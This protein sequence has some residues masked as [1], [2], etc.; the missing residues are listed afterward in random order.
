M[1]LQCQ[2]EFDN[3]II[4]SE[5]YINLLN[6]NFDHLNKFVDANVLIYKD[7]EAYQNDKTEVVNLQYICRDQVTFDA[8]F[9]L[10]VLNQVD[11][12]P[13]SQSYIWLKTFDEF[14]SAIDV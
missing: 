8:Y 11:V 7:A 2:F 1:A 6:V 12:N 4:L 13:I 10:D 3:G 5:A 14:S 9:A